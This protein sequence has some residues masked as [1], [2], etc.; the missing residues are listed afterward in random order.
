VTTGIVKSRSKVNKW[1]P[2]G[3]PKIPKF[4]LYRH[5]IQ[6]ACIQESGGASVRGCRA[7]TTS[8][9]RSDVNVAR[10]HFRGK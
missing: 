8:S 6:V 9:S 5:D 1:L 3:P 2:A 4:V 10:P 7:A